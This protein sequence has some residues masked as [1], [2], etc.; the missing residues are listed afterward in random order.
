MS[1][2]RIV[3][4]LVGL[5]A[6]TLAVPVG[7]ASASGEIPEV[8]A[9]VQVSGSYVVA[10][11]D[12]LTGPEGPG[13]DDIIWYAPGS[14]TDSMWRSNGDT[15]FAKSSLSPQVNGSYDPIVGDFAGG[16]NQDVLW[17]AAGAAT[18]YL[19]VSTGTGFTTS[20]VAVNGTYQPVVLEN[21]RFGG[22][23]DQILWHAFGPAPESVW[24]FGPGTSHSSASLTAPASGIPV[25]GN[26]DGDTDVD[27]VWYGPGAETDRLWRNQGGGAFAGSALSIGGSYVPSVADFDSSD[28]ADC[29]DIFWYRTSPGTDPYWTGKANGTFGAGTATVD[30]GGT[31]ISM[32]RPGDEWVAIWRPFGDLGYWSGGALFPYGNAAI[33]DG[34]HPLV[35]TFEGSA[36]D[37]LWYKP[38][39]A[40]ERFF[41][42]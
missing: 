12:F 4:V 11:G 10:V 21:T 34:Y 19:W 1:R 29:D 20:T 16:P 3:L 42:I 8:T 33:A 27:L 41:V 28:C 38:G 7:P 26:F 9:G 15:S 30:D 39:G 35:G 6:V 17:Y 13:L 24:T 37:I 31:G 36:E 2:L 14:G 5:L 40:P 18:D 23:K 32:H 25:P 22:P